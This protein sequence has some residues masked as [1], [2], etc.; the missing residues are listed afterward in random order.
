MRGIGERNRNIDPF[1]RQ[2]RARLPTSN[3]HGP[4]IAEKYYDSTQLSSAR[5]GRMYAA[6]ERWL[7]SRTR[8]RESKEIVIQF[9]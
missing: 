2:A 8:C 9:W 6:P 5:Y 1:H 7:P 3:H 4:Q